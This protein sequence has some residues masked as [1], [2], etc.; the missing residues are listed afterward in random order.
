REGLR[1]SNQVR[2]MSGDLRFRYDEN[3]IT[4]SYLGFWYQDP[5]GLHFRYKLENFDKGWIESRNRF[6]TY[7]S[8]PPGT[9][10]FRLQVS[11]QFGF[12][13]PQ[14]AALHFVIRP[15]FWKT[16]GFYAGR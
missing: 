5:E 3:D 12:N 6:V 1:V 2:S 8:L 10:T 11:D 14:S 7:S 9:Y 13:D 4:I 16:Q 15:P